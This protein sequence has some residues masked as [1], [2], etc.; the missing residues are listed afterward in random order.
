[1]INV[2][3]TRVN[4]FVDGSLTVESSSLT[5]TGFV[6][7]VNSFTKFLDT[8]E[9]VAESNYRFIK[10]LILRVRSGFVGAPCFV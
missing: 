5:Y 7:S 4:T 9:Y 2:V 6:S 1:M 8:D 3:F 10:T